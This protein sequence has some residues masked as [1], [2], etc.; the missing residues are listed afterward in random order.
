MRPSPID[1]IVTR[2]AR[3]EFARAVRFEG[4]GVPRIPSPSVEKP[5]LLYLHVPFCE[6]LCP[7]CSFNR[8]IFQ[9]HLARSYFKALQRE[10]ALYRDLGNTFTGIYVGGGT[11]TVLVEEL[12][13][14]LDLARGLFPNRDIS[15]ETNPN[16]LTDANLAV[17][18][19]AGVQRLSVCVQ[20]FDD[21]L[22]RK[23]ERYEKYGSGEEIAGRLAAVQVRF[24]QPD[25][26]HDLQLP[27]PDPDMLQR[28]L[29][30]SCES[31][32]TRRPIT[33]SWSPTPPGISLPK[34][35]GGCP[36]T[37]RQTCTDG[38][39]NAS[40]PITPVVGLVLLP[41]GLHDRRIHR[42]LR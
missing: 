22:L 39:G 38:S 18:V 20:S 16:H 33:P 41:Q 11:P 27:H 40:G 7:Y 13:A 35:W 25:C 3:R 9:P 17:L 37:G 15:V 28:D 4:R 12:A 5:R 6:R 24:P 29:D 23:M 2:V 30:T 31:P 19:Q 1:G 21:G 26:G 8:V 14:V 34:P 42:R 10:I 32:W 36:T